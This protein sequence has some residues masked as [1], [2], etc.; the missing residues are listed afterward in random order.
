[1]VQRLRADPRTAGTPIVI[2]SAD[3]TPDQPH[4]LIALG[5]TSYETKPVNVSRLL[6]LIDRLG[7]PAAQ[8]ST[9]TIPSRFNPG[10]GSQSSAVSEHTNDGVATMLSTFRHEMVNLLGVVL[11]YCDLLAGDETKPSKLTWIEKQGTATERDI[12]LTEEL[13]VPAPT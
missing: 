13:R 12:E 8:L 6:D 7:E 11:N 5:A 2:L 4:R 3:A 1:M 10:T 9:A